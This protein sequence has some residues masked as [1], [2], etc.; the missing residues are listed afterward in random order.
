MVSLR[1]WLSF[2]M[3][4]RCEEKKNT[5]IT[6]Y[7]D[8]R[9]WIAV[10]AILHNKQPFRK[11]NIENDKCASHD[12]LGVFAVSREALSSSVCLDLATDPDVSKKQKSIP[13]THNP[14]ILSPLYTPEEIS[15]TNNQIDRHIISTPLH[16]PSFG[17]ISIHSLSL[18]HKD[19]VL[20]IINPSIK[21]IP[22]CR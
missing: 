20:I 7:N 16:P 17:Q 6:S 10:A 3:N 22:Y 13:K 4:T 19:K 21:Q 5:Q 9:H 8:C 15:Q 18:S 1:V 12:I 14:M 11:T 2:L